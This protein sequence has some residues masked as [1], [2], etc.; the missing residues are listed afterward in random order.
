MQ[1]A[2]ILLRSS[3]SRAQGNQV[4]ADYVDVSQLMHAGGVLHTSTY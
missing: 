3:W 4:A 2:A 1:R